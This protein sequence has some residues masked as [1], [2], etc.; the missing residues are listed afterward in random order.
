MADE[1]EE[2]H[3]YDHDFDTSEAGED[4][5][6]EF[7]FER[8]VY[9]YRGDVAKARARFHRAGRDLRNMNKTRFRQREK[10]ELLERYDETKEENRTPYQVAKE[11]SG[12]DAVML[13]RT[14]RQ[15]ER[16]LGERA[17]GLADGK[18]DPPKITS[19][20]SVN[21]PPDKPKQNC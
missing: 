1:F 20:S 16:A 19:G 8:F 12:G 6:V 21:W 9:K 15:I 11:M 3:V 18:W 2:H 17:E 13:D 14:R 5:R 4:A 7:L 10:A